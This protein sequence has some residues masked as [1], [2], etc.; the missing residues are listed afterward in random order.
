MS[1]RNDEST[2]IIMVLGLVFTAMA[3]FAVVI[4]VILGCISL[5]L[6]IL[7]LFAWFRPVQIGDQYLMPEEARI[8]VLRGVIGA[9]L[10]AAFIAFLD[11]VL[12]YR[13]DWSYASWY[14]VVGYV[15]GT[16]GVEILIAESQQS[17]ASD[18]EILPPELPQHQYQDRH[19]YQHQPRSLPR[20]EAE[21]FRYASWDDEEAG[22]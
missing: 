17:T 3:A 22:R 10:V 5:Y 11:F 12:G 8:F 13:I 7:A 6:T 21:P 15:V 1:S 9:V 18:V 2:A 16:V 19:Q 4:F 14:T 20:R